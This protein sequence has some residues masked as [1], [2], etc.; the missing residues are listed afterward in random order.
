MYNIL[1][2]AKSRGMNDTMRPRRPRPAVQPAG[3]SH[4]TLILGGASR[5][6]A[7]EPRRAADPTPP[8]RP[9][10]SSG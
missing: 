8:P 2:L 9:H 4:F 3:A 6:P 7:P 10:P 5:A 1:H